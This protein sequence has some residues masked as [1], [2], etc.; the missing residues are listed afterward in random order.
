MTCV[1]SVAW[2]PYCIKRLCRPCFP[3]I[4]GYKYD[5]LIGLKVQK[6][7]SKTDDLATFCLTIGKEG[8]FQISWCLDFDIP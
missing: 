8:A 4:D 5:N 1:E 3:Y 2:G 7:I 6:F